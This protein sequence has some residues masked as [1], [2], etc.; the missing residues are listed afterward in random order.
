MQNGNPFNKWLFQI[1][2]W[3][4]NLTSVRNVHFQSYSLIIAYDDVIIR[5]TYVFAIGKSNNP[6]SFPHQ[7]AL[8]WS[9]FGLCYLW[10]FPPK[11]NTKALHRTLFWI[12][13]L[14]T[15]LSSNL[16]N[17]ATII[18]TKSTLELYIPSNLLLLW[19]QSYKLI[20]STY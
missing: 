2:I 5:P 4:F 13:H 11:Q 10:P 14:D 17:G 8:L 3:Q 9:W 16:I 6:N 18:T 15:D 19:D 12:A 7:P 1:I 20:P